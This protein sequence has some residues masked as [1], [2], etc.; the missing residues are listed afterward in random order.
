MYIVNGIPHTVKS[1]ILQT[2]IRRIV[3]FCSDRRKKFDFLNQTVLPRWFFLFSSQIVRNR[4]SCPVLWVCMIQKLYGIL[5]IFGSKWFKFVQFMI[6]FIF[7]LQIVQMVWLLLEYSAVIF[8]LMCGD[9][10]TM[11]KQ[12]RLWHYKNHGI[13]MNAWNG[14]VATFSWWIS[15]SLHIHGK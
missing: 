6:R 3:E 11:C 7:H 15:F 10:M 1:L 9:V 13:K 12:K 8:R 5:L 2:K 4:M 14:I